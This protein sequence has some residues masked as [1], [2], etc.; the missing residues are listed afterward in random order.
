MTRKTTS[1]KRT[2]KKTGWIIQV[3]GDD[4]E[5]N[6]VKGKEVPVVYKTK[7]EA[8]EALNDMITN[9]V[10]DVNEVRKKSRKKSTTDE[11]EG[12]LHEIVPLSM[13][14]LLKEKNECD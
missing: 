3:Q 12:E 1:K 5:I 6:C 11:E 9:L 10:E 14:S 7:K 4:V 13:S 8:Q 2:A